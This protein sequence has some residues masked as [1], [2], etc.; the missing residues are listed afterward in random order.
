MHIWT[1]VIPMLESYCCIFKTQF[2]PVLRHLKMTSF[3]RLPQ[4]VVITYCRCLDSHIWETI[5]ASS[6]TSFFLSFFS[7][8]PFLFNTLLMV[9]FS[10][11][12]PLKQTQEWHVIGSWLLILIRL[13]RIDS[14]QASWVI[15][16]S[17]ESSCLQTPTNLPSPAWLSFLLPLKCHVLGSCVLINTTLSNDSSKARST[18]P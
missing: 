14:C 9:L 16:F 3:K 1:I 10:S 15:H 6:S 5:G 7:C 11:C 12:P 18:K 13:F 4:W 8:F 17:L 2:I